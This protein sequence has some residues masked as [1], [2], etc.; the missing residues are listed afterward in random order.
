MSRRRVLFR[1][2]G[3]R[4]RGSSGLIEERGRWREMEVK[5][6]RD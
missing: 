5:K 1:R 2:C 4:G 3:R 6:T